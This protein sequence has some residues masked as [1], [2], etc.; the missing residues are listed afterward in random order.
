MF[1]NG[2]VSSYICEGGM[3]MM[4]LIDGAL[5]SSFENPLICKQSDQLPFTSIQFLV[6]L[7]QPIDWCVRVVCPKTSTKNDQFVSPSLE[8]LE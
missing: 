3:G 4:V 6:G 2:D 8:G 7:S 5:L 1:P